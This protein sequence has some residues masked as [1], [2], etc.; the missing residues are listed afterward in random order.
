MKLRDEDQFLLAERVEL[1]LQCMPRRE[2]RSME[3][4]RFGIKTTSFLVKV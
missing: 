4:R 1:Q 3:L 2:V